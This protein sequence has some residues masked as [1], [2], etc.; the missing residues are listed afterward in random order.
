MFPVQPEMLEGTLICVHKNNVLYI[1]EHN[2][3][4]ITSIIGND[5][6]GGYLKNYGINTFTD[7]KHY[8]IINS[9]GELDFYFLE[10]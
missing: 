9:Y 6:C 1:I 7:L 10:A 5:A 3:S 2:Y 4:G 8:D